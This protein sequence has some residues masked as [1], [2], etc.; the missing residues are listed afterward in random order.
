MA[1]IVACA[2]TAP[3][4]A[5][6]ING[7]ILHRPLQ[8]SLMRFKFSAPPKNA[9]VPYALDFCIG[10]AANPCGLPSSHVINVPEGQERFADFDSALFRTNILVVGQGTRVAVPF[11]VE[12]E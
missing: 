6:T 12:V 8:P 3:A 2:F 5:Y 10:P 4:L 7:T 11:S 9:G 1:A